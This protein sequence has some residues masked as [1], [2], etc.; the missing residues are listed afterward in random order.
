MLPGPVADWTFSYVH[1]DDVV[2]A[3]LHVATHPACAGGIYNVA[4]EPPLSF[5]EAF[6][7]SRPCPMSFL[8]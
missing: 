2:R 8:G 7:L 1:V 5:A 4:V 6:A 3:T